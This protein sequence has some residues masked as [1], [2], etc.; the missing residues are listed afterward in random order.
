MMVPGIS[1]NICKSS[2]HFSSCAATMLSPFR[3]VTVFSLVI[4]ISVSGIHAQ[5]FFDD[6]LDADTDLITYR[7]DHD[8]SDEHDWEQ[9]ESH[10]Q[11]GLAHDVHALKAKSVFIETSSGE[12]SHSGASNEHIDRGHDHIRHE[13][14][15]SASDQ[16]SFDSNESNDHTSSIGSGASHTYSAGHAP[17]QPRMSP[18]QPRLAPIEGRLT[19]IEPRLTPIEP[20]LT[21]TAPRLIP[22]GND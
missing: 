4:A 19:P 15:D 18:I 21:P 11:G 22:T 5:D 14:E 16:D 6:D 8:H 2:R 17:I 9:E 13:G 20:Q 10:G 1:G 12:M 3:P 7:H